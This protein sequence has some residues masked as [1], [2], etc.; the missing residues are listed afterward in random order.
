MSAAR[1]ILPC[2]IADLVGE[3]AYCLELLRGGEPEAMGGLKWEVIS[4]CKAFYR[5]ARRDR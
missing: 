4:E 3:P 2:L 1:D 5:G